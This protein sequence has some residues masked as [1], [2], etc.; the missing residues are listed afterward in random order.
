MTTAADVR[1]PWRKLHE[2]DLGVGVA[3]GLSKE[4]ALIVADSLIQADLR[5]VDTH[6]SG[7]L[8]GYWAQFKRG[9]YNIEPNVHIVKESPA[10]ALIDAD[11][12]PGQVA[13]VFAMKVAMQ[14]AR[15]AGV[16]WTEVFN[17]THHGA[18]AYYAIMAADNDMVGIVTTNAGPSVA[19]YG[20]RA[21][22]IG[23][24]PL[25]IAAPV[26]GMKPLVLD[27]AMSIKAQGQLRLAEEKGTLLPEGLAMDKD[28]HPT[29]DYRAAREGTLF[30]FGG[31]KGSGLAL[32][33]EVL[34]SALSG[35]PHLTQLWGEGGGTAP[36]KDPRGGSRSHTLVAL[37]I[38][39]F[40]DPERFKEDT[41]DMVWQFKDCTRL[42]GVS[43]IFVPGEIEW[44]NYEER[45]RNGVPVNLGMLHR[46][47]KVGQEAGVPF[48][49]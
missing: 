35:S 42:P 17:S 41:A 46:L 43:E 49:A 40:T 7:L 30:P 15:Q 32:M 11:R 37:N 16:G 34:S 12:A 23:N 18:L 39:F 20:G 13:S 4:H 25:A 9:S 3:A 31:Y 26:K 6:G 5:G 27:M 45:E 21:R 47:Q 38:A 14:K 10:A 1:V 8:P 24:N 48:P 33:L 44:H 29:R 28:G 19:P 36:G 22:V 2:F